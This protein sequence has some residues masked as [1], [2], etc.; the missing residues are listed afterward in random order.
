MSKAKNSVNGGQIIH[1]DKD[2]IKMLK[3][4]GKLNMVRNYPGHLI[5]IFCLR[6]GLFWIK[7]TLPITVQVIVQKIM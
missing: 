6:S 2:N 7:E 1:M 4:G 5:P 3:I